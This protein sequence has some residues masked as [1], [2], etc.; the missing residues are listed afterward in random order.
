MV[1]SAVEKFTA[2]AAKRAVTAP[3]SPQLVLSA[4][5]ELV[6]LGC[7]LPG[8]PDGILN[9][10]T[11]TALGRFM[12]VKGRSADNLTVTEALVSELTK[13]IDR[14]CPPE[15]KAGEM[16]KGDICVPAQK[17][18]QPPAAEKPAPPAATS[19]RKDDD[20]D[21]RRKPQPQPEKR[22]AEKEQRRPAPAPAAEPRARQ[23]AVARPSGGGGGGGGGGHTMIGVGF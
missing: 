7:T 2:E 5:T 8:K 14:L 13:Q 16:A 10:A 9:A 21:A 18:A 4:Q 22:Q 1:A 11:K 17:P 3:N 6:R 20:D 23:Q 15:C 19:R 12:T